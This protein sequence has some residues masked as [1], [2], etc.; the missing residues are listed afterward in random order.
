MNPTTHPRQSARRPRIEFET[1]AETTSVAIFL[2]QDQHIVYANPAVTSITGYSNDELLGLDLWQLAHPD[3][4][5][6]VKKLGIAQA[7]EQAELDP[8]RD[9]PRLVEAGEARDEIIEAVVNRHRG[10]IVARPAPRDGS[11]ALLDV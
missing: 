9:R 8:K 2:T 11:S 4:Q 7:C 10:A 6:G 3:Y 1:L 5:A